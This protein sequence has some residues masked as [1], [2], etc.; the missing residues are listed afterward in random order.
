MEREELCLI[1][2]HII[3]DRWEDKCRIV[4]CVDE[5]GRKVQRRH[6]QPFDKMTCP[7]FTPQKGA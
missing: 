5:S 1:C 7:R 6:F 3:N 4:E 2:A